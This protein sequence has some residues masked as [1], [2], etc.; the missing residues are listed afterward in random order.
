ML[1]LKLTTAGM[2]RVLEQRFSR[3]VLGQQDWHQLFW[4]W[5]LAV[6]VLT[7]LV[8]DSNVRL[9]LRTTAL[10]P[11]LSNSGVTNHICLFQ[12]KL[13]KFK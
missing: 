7:S 8:S 4:G 12:F 6:C 11:V 3:V 9:C 13:V 1:T 2:V 10:R 5:D